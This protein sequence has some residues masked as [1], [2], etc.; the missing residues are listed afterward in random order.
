MTES[1]VELL[2]TAKLEKFTTGYS[3]TDEEAMAL[4]KINSII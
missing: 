3:A 2:K 1:L 4:T